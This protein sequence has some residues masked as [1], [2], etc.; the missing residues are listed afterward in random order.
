M[1]KLM[2]GL[3]ILRVCE[4]K[5]A[6]LAVVGLILITM[7]VTAFALTGFNPFQVLGLA[8]GNTFVCVG[9]KLIDRERE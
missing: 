3:L 4:H 2:L 7:S 6:V 9:A 1:A 8:I 5:T